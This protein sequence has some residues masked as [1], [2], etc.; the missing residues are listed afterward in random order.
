[1]SGYDERNGQEQSKYRSRSNHDSLEKAEE[2]KA[3]AHW[4]IVQLRGTLGEITM[5]ILLSMTGH[6]QVSGALLRPPLL[7]HRSM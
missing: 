3:Q 5:V 4:G 6:Y 7:R 1:M 2:N